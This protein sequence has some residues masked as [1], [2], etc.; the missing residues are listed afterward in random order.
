MARDVKDLQRLVKEL[1]ALS[2]EERARV[3]ADAMRA[4]RFHS[5]AKGWSPPV[6]SGGTHW[7]GGSLSREELYGDDGR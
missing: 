5:P 1:A 3:I 2:P 4:G 7:D 6:L